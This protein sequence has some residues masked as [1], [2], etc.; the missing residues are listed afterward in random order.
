MAGQVLREGAATLVPMSKGERGKGDTAK[1][2]SS[3]TPELE[4]LLSPGTAT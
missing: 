2:G 4:L 3:Q 1:E